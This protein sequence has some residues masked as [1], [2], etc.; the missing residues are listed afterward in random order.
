MSW[1]MGQKKGKNHGQL[2][3]DHYLVRILKDTRDTL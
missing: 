3:P 1:E 2:I